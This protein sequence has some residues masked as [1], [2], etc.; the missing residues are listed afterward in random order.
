M[1]RSMGPSELEGAPTGSMG[2][3]VPVVS[4]SF[5]FIIVHEYKS[6]MP[7][8]VSSWGLTHKN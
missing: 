5:L 1:R 7:E 2:V 3:M 6:V 8:I 4:H